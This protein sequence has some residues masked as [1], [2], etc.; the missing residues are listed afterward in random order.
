MKKVTSFLA[1]AFAST[2][3]FTMIELL[4]VTTIIILLTAIGL[5]GYRQVGQS[6]RDGKLYR[7]F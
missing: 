2:A 5:V 1:S 3:G 6:A 7:R 4:V